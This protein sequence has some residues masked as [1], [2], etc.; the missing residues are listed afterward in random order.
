LF[1]RVC[2][3]ILSGASIVLF[4]VCEADV[5]FL[6]VYT[7]WCSHSLDMSQMGFSVECEHVPHGVLCSYRSSY[8]CVDIR[9]LWTSN[10]DRRDAHLLTNPPSFY[11][12]CTPILI[13]VFS[14]AQWS[15]I[16][17]NAMP[18]TVPLTGSKLEKILLVAPSLS[19]GVHGMRSLMDKSG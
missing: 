3:E 8:L 1:D 12:S 19:L 7:A 9:C 11:C 18:N 17:R 14:A 6:F 16:E 13:I 15:P 10:A 5:R 4:S 2:I